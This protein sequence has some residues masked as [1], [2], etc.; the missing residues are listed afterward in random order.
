M[1]AYS[2]VSNVSYL[3]KLILFKQSLISTDESEAIQ[4]RSLSEHGKQVTK[5]ENTLEINRQLHCVRKRITPA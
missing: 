1:Y 3:E 5:T 4:R 2:I